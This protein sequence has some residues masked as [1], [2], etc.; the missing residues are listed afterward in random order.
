MNEESVNLCES[1]GN[2]PVK[3]NNS[4]AFDGN[5]AIQNASEWEESQEQNHLKYSDKPVPIL[6]T[7][8]I[9]DENEVQENTLLKDYITILRK[10]PEL[11]KEKSVQKKALYDTRQTSISAAV[12]QPAIL[13]LR[14]GLS[15]EGVSRLMK[16]HAR[17]IGYHH[18]DVFRADFES[19]EIIAANSRPDDKISSSLAS[20]KSTKDL[21]ARLR[22]QSAV[23]PVNN[24]IL[25]ILARRL[26]LNDPGQ[27]PSKQ[28]TGKI[29]LLT[30]NIDYIDVDSFVAVSSNDLYLFYKEILKY[31]LENIDSCISVK[32]PTVNS[33]LSM[34]FRPGVSFDIGDIRRF[35]AKNDKPKLR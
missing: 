25:R 24:N 22:Q 35:A 20:L 8:E 33:L 31:R 27:S 12:G 5:V 18:D 7:S 16:I 34:F 14:H 6:E 9:L 15:R 29:S 10:W 11:I 3:L 19:S 4:I 1:I 13:A 28:R 21:L 23:G 32:M 26:E 17:F 30:T 2:S